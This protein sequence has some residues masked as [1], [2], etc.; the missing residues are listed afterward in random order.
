MCQYVTCEPARQIERFH[1]SSGFIYGIRQKVKSLKKM[2]N[3]R[4]QT[5]LRFIKAGW[6]K[7]SERT[8]T[9]TLFSQLSRTEAS[10]P[11]AGGHQ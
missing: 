3:G 10:L 2:F 8:E 9:K 6:L 5:N 1:K 11:A 4:E 7:A